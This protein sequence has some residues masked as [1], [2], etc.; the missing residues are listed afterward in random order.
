MQRDD[1]ARAAVTK[2]LDI[3]AQIPV[4]EAALTDLNNQEKELSGYVDALLGKRRDMMEALEQFVASR[5]QAASATGLSAGTN[6]AQAKI[7]KADAAFGRIFQRQT[8]ITMAGQ[9]VSVEQEAK[10]KELAGLVQDKRIEARL[11]EI[12]ASQK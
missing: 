2:Q 4:I 6:N 8:G 1:L 9:K 3:E 7:D 11:A 10:L 5:M 12:K